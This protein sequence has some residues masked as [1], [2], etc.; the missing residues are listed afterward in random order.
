MELVF[1]F[2]WVNSQTGIAR[3]CLMGFPWVYLRRNLDT[4]CNTGVFLGKQLLPNPQQELSPSLPSAA[5]TSVLPP[6]SSALPPVV[7]LNTPASPSQLH[8]S[9]AYGNK[10]APD[11]R[12]SYLLQVLRHDQATQSCV[13]GI[14]EP[15][16]PKF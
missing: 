5:S 7:P 14:C 3:L 9:Q 8:S 16:V 12:A 2:L 13:R 10:A 6:C 15:N 11:S 1:H 4:R